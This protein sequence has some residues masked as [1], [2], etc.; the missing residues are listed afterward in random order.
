MKVFN[1]TDVETRQLRHQG[2]VNVP[3]RISDKHAVTV[4]K[5]GEMAEVKDTPAMRKHLQQTYVSRGAMALDRVPVDYKGGSQK[6]EPL[7]PPPPDDSTDDA[8]P[9]KE[10]ASSV[11]KKKVSGKK[12]G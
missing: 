9:S 3:I 8:A 5:P 10:E 2:L 12:S 11:F 4:I 1:L 7:L 6:V